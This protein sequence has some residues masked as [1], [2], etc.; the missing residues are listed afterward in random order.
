MS[1]DNGAM[2]VLN[3]MTKGPDHIPH[4]SLNLRYTLI[5]LLL[6]L[7]FLLTQALD[8]WIDLFVLFLW[9]LAKEVYGEDTRHHVEVALVVVLDLATKVFPKEFYLYFFDNFCLFYPLNVMQE[10]KC[11]QEFQI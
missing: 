9:L 5:L 6:L 1:V 2:G 3:C 10:T 8:C 4:K 11:S 7:Q